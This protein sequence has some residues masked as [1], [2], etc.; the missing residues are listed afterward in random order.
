ML[1]TNRQ[2]CDADGAVLN[3]LRSGSRP[4]PSDPCGRTGGGRA[5]RPSGSSSSGSSERPSIF[6]MSVRDLGAGKFAEGL[7]QVDV[8]GQRRDIDAFAQHALPAPERRHMGSAFVGRAFAGL[9]AGGEHGDSLA[10]AFLPL[11]PAWPLSVMKM[12]SVLS[13]GFH[14]SSFC[15][16]RPK[17]SSMF[18]IMP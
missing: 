6:W 8:G 4:S 7:E 1:F 5:T 15:I 9:E 12:T 16:S 18:S 10:V 11:R 17:L 3:L 2:R 13:H 14:S